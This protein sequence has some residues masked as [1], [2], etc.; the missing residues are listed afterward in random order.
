MAKNIYRTAQGQLVDI[1]TLRLVNEDAVAVGNMSVNARGDRI[2]SDGTVL[3]TRNEIMKKRYNANT[4]FLNQEDLSLISRNRVVAQ[5]TQPEDNDSDESEVIVPAPANPSLRG[6]L[7]S[8]LAAPIAVNNTPTP[9]KTPKV[10][11]I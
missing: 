11:R 3:E 6:S 5:S 2:A 10:K 1:D 4:T 9:S 8:S 7:A